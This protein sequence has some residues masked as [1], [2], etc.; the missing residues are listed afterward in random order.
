MRYCIQ[1]Q[2][3]IDNGVRKLE[4]R[5]HVKFLYDQVW[6]MRV[7]S[8]AARLQLTTSAAAAHGRYTTN[9]G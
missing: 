5:T 4:I 3:A 1:L 8:F 9:E 2:A 6:S 7:V